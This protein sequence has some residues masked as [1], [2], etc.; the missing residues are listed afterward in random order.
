MK[1][2]HSALYAI[3]GVLYLAQKKDRDL[4]TTHEI[5]ESYN[6]SEIHLAKMFQV[7]ARRGLLRSSRGRSGGFGLARPPNQITML[8]VIE[9]VEGSFVNYAQMTCSDQFH[10]E[11]DQ[12]SRQMDTSDA[13]E[14]PMAECQPFGS[15]TVGD[16]A[17]TPS[18]TS[19][20]IKGQQKMLDTWRQAT[21]DRL[22][23]LD[24]SL[25]TESRSRAE[26]RSRIGRIFDLAIQVELK[27]SAIYLTL[28]TQFWQ[29][30]ELA[31]IWYNLSLEE[32]GHA[33]WLEMERNLFHD[34]SPNV[35]VEEPPQGYSED[36]LL[37]LL[38]KLAR[39][40]DE[41]NRG[42]VSKPRSFEIFQEIES[43]ISE[44][45]YPRVLTGY[46]E[47]I[48]T[49]LKS[50]FVEESQFH[51]LMEQHAQELASE[52]DVSVPKSRNA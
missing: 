11:K 6:I 16:C 44:K 28:H 33:S 38:N 31:Y 18:V 46:D 25:R 51:C 43:D 39:I 15:L 50:P 34:Q 8:E 29:H 17:G 21:F 36:Q 47:V 52:S 49:L 2:S 3:Q 27:A 35:A 48:G 7:L 45:N 12:S 10:C 23:E 14:E 9:A 20:L 22:V 26:N 30:P 1:L 40:Q 13:F 24:S 19:L 4:I 32:K 42:E 5:S 41:V 37:Q